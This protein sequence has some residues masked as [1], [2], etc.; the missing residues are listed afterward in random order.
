MSVKEIVTLFVL[1]I[2]AVEK[3]LKE[4]DAQKMRKNYTIRRGRKRITKKDTVS[5]EE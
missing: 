4:E 1:E 2:D 3:I 5:D